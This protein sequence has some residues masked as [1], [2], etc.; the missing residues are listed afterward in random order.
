MLR[1][2]VPALLLLCIALAA[3][4]LRAQ[5]TTTGEL[6]GM[7]TDPSG[8]VLT[9]ANVTL[10]NVATGAKQTT[11]TSSTGG[12]HF[13]LLRPGTYKISA[14]AK[15]GTVV[16]TFGIPQPALRSLRRTVTVLRT[17]QVLVPAKV[18]I[19]VGWQWHRPNLTDSDIRFHVADHRFVL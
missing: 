9:N 10:T 12:Y 14:A 5:T 17:N 11:Q 19:S 7:V 16:N 4:Q 1:R 8:A 3:W 18:S 15:P 13:L 6:A 2:T